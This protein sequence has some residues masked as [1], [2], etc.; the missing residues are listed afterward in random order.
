[1][2]EC[3]NV[4]QFWALLSVFIFGLGYW[5]GLMIGENKIKAVENNGGEGK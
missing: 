2:N 4:H 3:L 5:I 1:M